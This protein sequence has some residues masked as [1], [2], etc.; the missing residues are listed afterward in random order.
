MDQ[1]S[2]EEAVEFEQ[3]EIE[4]EAEVFSG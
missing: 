3:S 2:V 4:A 1:K